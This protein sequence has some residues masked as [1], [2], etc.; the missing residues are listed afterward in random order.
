PCSPCPT[1]FRS[2]QRLQVLDESRKMLLEQCLLVQHG[3]DDGQQRQRILLPR[4]RPFGRRLAWAGSVVIMPDGADLAVHKRAP[5]ITILIGATL[6]HRNLPVKQAPH[7]P[8]KRRM[9]PSDSMIRRAHTSISWLATRA[10]VVRA[11]S[12][13]R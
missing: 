11:A 5:L 12:D 1:L 4:R 6:L 3:H 13:I 10:A 9:R 2:F 7:S 8:S